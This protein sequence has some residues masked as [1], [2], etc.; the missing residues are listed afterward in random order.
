[1]TCPTKVSVVW[2]LAHTDALFAGK[3]GLKPTLHRLFSDTSTIGICAARDKF[4]NVETEAVRAEVGEEEDRKI[5]KDEEGRD[6]ALVF[7]SPMFL[8]DSLGSGQRSGWVFRGES[9]GLGSADQ[10]LSSFAP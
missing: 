3:R 10:L 9:S 2:A 8:S 5:Q 4:W 7:P 6:D 1:M